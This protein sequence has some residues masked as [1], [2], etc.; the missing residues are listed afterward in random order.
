M[1]RREL[2]VPNLG[3]RARGLAHAAPAVRLG[4]SADQTSF[5][6][7][8]RNYPRSPAHVPCGHRALDFLSS[9]RRRNCSRGAVED[10]DLAVERMA[11]YATIL[12]ILS[13]GRGTL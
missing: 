13:R 3:V 6:W 7:V 11:R 12:S 10:R 4:T 9:A 1:A 8:H 5:A 2:Y